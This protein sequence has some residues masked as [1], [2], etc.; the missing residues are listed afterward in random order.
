M[1]VVAAAPV[2][3]IAASALVVFLLQAGLLLLL[4]V[5]LGRLATRLGMAAVVG[6]LCAGVLFGP[7]VLAHVAPAFSDWLLPQKA[8][9]MHLLDAVGQIGVLLLVG[10]TGI[11]LDLGLVRRQGRTAAR[12]SLA[13]L[14]L[15]LGLGIGC[16]LLL[17]ASLLA[18]RSDRA[19]FAMF[20]G[21]AMCVSAI[22][23]IAKIL[24]DLGLLHR[25]IGQLT[26][27]AAVVDDVIGWLLLS[28]VSAMAAAGVRGGQIATSV[29]A[30]VGVLVFALVI[31][32]PVVRGA[33]KAASRSGEPVATT[34]A[35]VVVLMLLASAATQALKLEAVLGA[36]V[37]GILIGSSGVV[38][39]KQLA[40]LR[41]LVLAVLAPLFFAT[42][43]L[44]MDLTALARPAVLASAVVVL[45]LAILGKFAGAYIG[46]KLSRL[47]RWESLA[48]GAG[49][50]A[51]GVI[52]VVVATVGLR[53][54]V[55][56]TEAYTIVI[57]VA[58]VTSLM[59]PPVLRYALGR[60]ETTASE[61]D[62]GVRYGVLV[63]AGSGGRE[64][65][66]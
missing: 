14:L 29:L 43:G 15:P 21:V 49:M 19:V 52:E 39:T 23:V 63:E 28:I 62:R 51:R 58:V 7:S 66:G 55:L 36:F 47:G 50:N 4:A 46:A 38:D 10:I 22:P 35:T 37:C 20:L 45:A 60:I 54:G 59:A 56:T 27:T 53:L 41:T 3:P 13:G 42:A 40:P 24:T 34:I 65:P 57:L 9:Q 1:A 5:A 11:F 6:E 12:V 33:L 31:G 8:D 17:P 16:G 64:Q 32:R 44:R 30:V 48:L 2:A 25:D 61:R 18:N 26:L